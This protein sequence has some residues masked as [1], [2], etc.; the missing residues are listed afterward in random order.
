LVPVTLPTPALTAL[1]ACAPA[2]AFP[3]PTDAPT[4]ATHHSHGK[5]DHEGPMG[6]DGNSEPIH[7]A[8]AFQASSSPSTA[9]LVV[10]TARSPLLIPRP[11]GWMANS[12]NARIK[13]HQQQRKSGAQ[14]IQVVQGVGIPRPRDW[15]NFTKGQRKNWKRRQIWNGQYQ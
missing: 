4:L 15:Q 10:N 5:A 12:R 2:P 14:S 7:G 13:W 11:H 8:L 1:L 9:P 3:L 6:R